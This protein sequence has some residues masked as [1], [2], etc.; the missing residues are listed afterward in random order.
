M[1]RAQSMYERSKGKASQGS[2]KRAKEMMSEDWA[3]AVHPVL[4]LRLHGLGSSGDQVSRIGKQ[5]QEEKRK[6]LLNAVGGF[7][8]NETVFEVG[9]KGNSE[10]AKLMKERRKALQKSVQRGL[11]STQTRSMDEESGDRSAKGQKDV[12]V[13]MADDDDIIVSFLAYC[14]CFETYHS[15]AGRLFLVIEVQR[16]RRAIGMRSFISHIRKRT[17]MPKRGK[18]HF[19]SWSPT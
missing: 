16:K 5:E 4:H 9:S 13:E 18:F 3:M 19:V 15:A 7:K 8:P 10:T 2:Y 12:D 11:G 1:L 6:K 17:L 14:A